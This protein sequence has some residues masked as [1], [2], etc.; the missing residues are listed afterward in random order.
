MSITLSTSSAARGA[1][2]LLDSLVRA[3]S[4][5]SEQQPADPTPALPRPA[6]EDSEPDITD[7][8]QHRDSEMLSPEP[9]NPAF[10][11]SG[12]GGG[13]VGSTLETSVAAEPGVGDLQGGDDGGDG[14]T[15]AGRPAALPEQAI[16]A[17]LPPEEQVDAEAALDAAAKLAA[18]CPPP[19]PSTPA[20]ILRCVCLCV[21]LCV[22]VCVCARVCACVRV[23]ACMR[24]CART[25]NCLFVP[26]YLRA[27]AQSCAGATHPA[28][29]CVQI[30]R[31]SDSFV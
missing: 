5:S 26:V 4:N 9:D 6:W 30:A 20:P 24:V 12:G 23:C 1:M 3:S 28:C 8:S 27:C 11:P 15:G 13:G 25:H 10:A 7:E 16:L 22:C 14:V 19:P 18:P 17:S 31:S 2:L 29:A 21:C